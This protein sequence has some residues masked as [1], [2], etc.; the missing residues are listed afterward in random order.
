MPLSPPAPVKAV[1]EMTLQL[2]PS[3]CS[4]RL[5]EELLITPTAQ[6][7]VDETVVTLFR[8]PPFFKGGLET[9]LQLVPFQCSISG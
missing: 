1:L 5:S 6:T 9:T 4:T 2:V 3:Q 8:K 7:S